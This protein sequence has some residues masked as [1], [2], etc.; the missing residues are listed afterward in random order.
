VALDALQ[1]LRG[2]GYDVPCDVWLTGFDDSSE[3]RV[4]MPALTTIHIHTQSMAYSAMHL[5][6][7]RMQEPNLE[8]RQVYTQTDLIYRESTDPEI[9]IERENELI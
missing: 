7:T 3:S 9:G 2:L 6:I 8:F 5:L 4:S 1:A